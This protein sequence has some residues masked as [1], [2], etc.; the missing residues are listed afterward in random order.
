MWIRFREKL[1]NAEEYRLI[2]VEGSVVYFLSGDRRERLHFKNPE[3]AYQAFVQ[4]ADRLGRDWRYLDL[5][6]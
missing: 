6:G 4:I 2:E 3:E 1:L 5:K